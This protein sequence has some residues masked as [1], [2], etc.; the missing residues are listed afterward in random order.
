MQQKK[1]SARAPKVKG[2]TPK[3]QAQAAQAQPRT[4]KTKS[5][6]QAAQFRLGGLD[7][8]R[9][10]AAIA[11]VLYHAFPS[12][13][14]G[15][16]LGVDV[17]FVLS[18]FLI[19]G[20]LVKEWHRDGK[21]AIGQFW[22]RRIRR[23][24]P[25]VA[26]MVIVMVPV[27]AVFSLDLVA[28]IRSQAAGALSFT[29]N[30]VLIWTDSSYFD[31]R[32]PQ[33]LTNMWTL[34]VEQQFYLLWPIV[35]LLIPLNRRESA[36]LPLVL[37]I[38]SAVGMAYLAYGMADPSRAYLGTDTH[39]FGLMLGAALALWL[40]RVV[41][42][43]REVV[44]AESAYVRGL[45]AWSGFAV[46]LVAFAVAS[47][48]AA[49]SY[50]WVTLMACFAT[51]AMIQAFVAP[52]QNQVG[53]ARTLRRFLD[54]EPLVWF[55]ERSY[56]VYLWHWPILVVLWYLFPGL[57]EGV[58]SIIVLILA[59]VLAALSFTFVES[60]MRKNG[61]IATL[62]TWLRLPEDEGADVR[63]A[64]IRRGAVGGLV[65]AFLAVSAFA[66]AQNELSQAQEPGAA[67][68]EG[69]GETPEGNGG[70]GAADATAEGGTAGTVAGGAVAGTTETHSPEGAGGSAGGSAAGSAAGSEQSPEATPIPANQI[71]FIGDS[72]TVMVEKSLKNKWPEMIIDGLK[73]R[74]SPQ[75]AG[76]MKQYADK[77]ELRSVV[78]IGVTSNSTLRMQQVESWL[79]LAGP[80]RTLVLVT[81]HG[82]PAEKYIW[83]SNNLIREAQAKYPNRIVIAPFDETI[84]GH[85]DTLYRDL[86]HPRPSGEQYYV[87]AINQALE[88]VSKLRAGK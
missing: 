14:G 64:W 47:D 3:T 45:V 32:V 59:T 11:V 21:I 80:D 81:G 85:E 15:G 46:M 5:Q 17:F 69:T 6:A 70:A 24:F 87:A 8:V 26:L 25:A 60:P 86:V 13:F 12:K 82:R 76:L 63:P 48:E 75:V 68:V 42:P 49:V 29:H 20:L 16:F 65:A 57:S 43:S 34:S 2:R 44:A 72:V 71:T 38:A 19:T 9:A 83:D 51:A 50:P 56:G 73:N 77:G 67:T 33:L 31:S 53:P 66:P 41:E 61:I 79:E 10:F 22:L 27:A 84:K 35:L 39:S 78:I 54:R 40:G 18:G 58:T 62:K 52:V 1:P 28:G 88:K 36:A 4:P 7:G 55:G 30:W 23:L 74:A 37:G